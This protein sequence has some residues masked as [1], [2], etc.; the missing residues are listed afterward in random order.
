M[1]KEV[2]KNGVNVT[3]L[4]NT[5]DQIDYDPEVA[6]FAYRAD[7]TWLGGTRSEAVVKDYYGALKEEKNREPQIIDMDEVEDLLG[8]GKQVSPAELLLVSLSGCFTKTLVTKAA[9]RDIDLKS[10]RSWYEGE[11][12]M[13]GSLGVADDVD[14]GYQSIHIDLVIDADIPADQKQELVDLAKRYSPVYNTISRSVPI[15][16]ELH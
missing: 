1:T 4:L 12:D 9:S 16:V 7:N 14:P 15:T 13:R 6:T 2:F 11:I 3:Q 10:V 8:G 5:I